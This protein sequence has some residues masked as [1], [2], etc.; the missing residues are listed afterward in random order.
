MDNGPGL[1]ACIFHYLDC[2]NKLTLITQGEEMTLRAATHTSTDTAS[3]SLN[4]E[5]IDTIR[6]H[7]TELA[8]RLHDRTRAVLAAAQLGDCTTTRGAL[9]EWYREELMPHIVAEERALY[10]AASE[11]DATRLLVCAMLTEHRALVSLVADLALTRDPFETATIAASAQALFTAH[12]GKENDLLLPALD[13]AGLD[14]A[15]LLEGMHEI[16]GATADAPAATGCGCGCGH[17]TAGE[18]AAPT[19]LQITDAPRQ[20]LAAQ[21][22]SGSAELDVRVLPHGQR[23]EIIFGRLDALAP[24]D[25]LVIVNDHDPKPLR[26]QTEALWPDQFTW[27]YREAGPQTWRVA[28]TRAH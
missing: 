16:L 14:L 5:V 19:V 18:Q 3:R 17:G 20:G 27:S 8:D 11:L 24:G 9:H 6:A 15:A 25:A 28:I 12:L 1:T 21:A 4:A 2:K 23:H 13:A 7:H 10:S 22:S 26:Y